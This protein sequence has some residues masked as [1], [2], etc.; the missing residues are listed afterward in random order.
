MTSS[1]PPPPPFSNGSS[2]I[3]IRI[4]SKL[5]H[6]F[7]T[8]TIHP[9]IR[10]SYTMECYHQQTKH[11]I[12]LMPPSLTPHHSIQFTPHWI[13]K[14]APNVESHQ[15]FHSIPF[16]LGFYT[17]TVFHSISRPCQQ[18]ATKPHFHK[19]NSHTKEPIVNGMMGNIPKGS[20]G[21]CWCI[22]F[23]YMQKPS[24]SGSKLKGQA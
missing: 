5:S 1:P 18:Q 2:R 11:Q 19:F 24:P 17:L 16:Q 12:H 10:I 7:S 13:S 22:Q 15:P 9:C 3:S 4:V 23:E 20:A 14:K 8:A 21:I 6:R